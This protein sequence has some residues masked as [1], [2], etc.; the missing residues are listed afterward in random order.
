MKVVII[1]GVAAGMSA[2]SKIKRI[3]KSAEIVVYEKGSYLSYGACGLP[4]YVAG[5]NEDHTKM[6]ARTKEEFEKSGMKIN[7]KHEVIK[8]MPENKEILV[9][10]LEDG[11]VFADSY[12]KLMIATGTIPIVP[13]LKGRGLKGVYVL[14]TLD[15]GLILKKA[16]E[17]PEVKDIIIVGGG[18]IGIEA[19]ETLSTKGKNIRIVELAPRIIQPFD[20][21]ITEMA[22]E[23]MMQGGIKLNL[24]EKVEEIIGSEKVIGVKT[25]KGSY[26]ANLVILAIGV[27]PA[28]EFLKDSG[29]ALAKN[30]AVVIDRE[31]RTNIDSIYSAGDCAEVYNKVKEENSF[32]PLGTNA[33]K[34]GRLAG[35]NITGKHNKYVGTLG[36]TAIKILDYEVA[37]TGLSESEAKALAIDYKTVFV[38]ASDH[39]G[40]YPDSTPI[41]IKLIYEEKSN[42]ILG[43]QAIGK[44]GVVLRIDMFAIA[45]HNNM[46]TMDLGMTDLCYAPPFSGVWDAVHIACNAAK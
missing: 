43:A 11:R 9:K 7:I 2:A 46:T 14:K 3:D 1:G 4:Y 12:D 39:P 37:K 44:K 34:C 20:A 32:I 29:I 36:S 30:G 13:P 18:Y 28:T 38:K 42:K 40:Y 33:N 23:I 24:N 5:M 10:D 19:A 26:E 22:S 35:E 31:M 15:D 41:W 17:A 45:I 8:I 25:D 16:V 6:I 27:K 21:E